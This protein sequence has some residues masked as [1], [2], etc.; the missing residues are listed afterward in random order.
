[1]FLLFNSIQLTRKPKKKSFNKSARMVKTAVEAGVVRAK[2]ARQKRKLENEA[3]KVFENAKST[4][5]IKGGNVSDVIT[6]VFKDLHRL[7][8]R[9]RLLKKVILSIFSVAKQHRLQEEEHRPAFRRR[10]LAGIL[11]QK[12]RL[13]PDRLRKSQQEAAAQLCHCQNIRLP[14]S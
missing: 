1:M 9:F 4:I 10:K 12:D 3:P 11:L 2:N 6:S 7:K 13:F 14:N 8:V 5:F